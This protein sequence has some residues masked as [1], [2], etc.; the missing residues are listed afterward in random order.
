MNYLS[1]YRLLQYDKKSVN[2]PKNQ[3]LRVLATEV[4]YP[5]RKFAIPDILFL[6]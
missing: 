5:L 1:H 3:F 2:D 6:C 4:V